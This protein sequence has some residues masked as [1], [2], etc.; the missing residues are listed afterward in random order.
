MFRGRTVFLASGVSKGKSR[1]CAVFD[2]LFATRLLA[3]TISLDC[4]AVAKSRGLSLLVSRMII[5]LS[6]ATS[7][8][9]L[10]LKPSVFAWDNIRLIYI[11]RPTA[12]LSALS[13]V[14]GNLNCMLPCAKLS[15][16]SCGLSMMSTPVSTPITVHI[17]HCSAPAAPDSQWKCGLSVA[18]ER[19]GN[20][21]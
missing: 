11:S 14:G 7:R 2:G 8:D 6:R 19:D 10:R 1:Q 18:D 17:L 4:M 20:R 15:E 3:H 21:V 16:I 9:K 12:W 13:E 5:W